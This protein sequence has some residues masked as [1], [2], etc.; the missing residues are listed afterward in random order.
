MNEKLVEIA[1]ENK[2]TPSP[3]AVDALWL[4]SIG[5]VMASSG[6][7][8]W[9]SPRPEVGQ[10]SVLWLPNA[11]LVVALLR[12]WGRHVFSVLAVAIFLGVGLVP[13]FQNDS[14]LGALVLLIVDIIEVG[15]LALGLALWFGKAFRLNSALNVAAFGVVTSVACL[16]GGF[17]A[18][19]VSQLPLGETVIATKAPL[20]V[21]VAWF[22]SDLATYFLV[23]APLL[24]VTGRGG[25]YIWSGLKQA[26]ISSALG[27]FFVMVL[28]FA[29][30]ALPQWL[31]AKTGLA[32]GSGG[33]I[34]VA[35][36]LATYLGFT[37]GP[38]IAA[39]VGAA[40]GVPAI[41]ATMAGIGPFGQGNAAANVFD[42]QAT[43]I[44]C[45]FTL[46]LIGAM[47]DEMRARSSALE[48]ALDEAIKM[49]QNRS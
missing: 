48:R 3:M 14:V 10:V 41:Y 5:V 1:N 19:I 11:I 24:A 49:R 26:P 44:V 42:M 43:L 7:W 39:I 17:L 18:A 12:N 6:I 4:I 38:A 36:P 30:F 16:I 32:L 29:G 40:I 21:G 23:A 13:A 20:Q 9:L 8:T 25:R 33:L 22:T 2:P 35:F 15:F 46:L 37:R 47:A 45:V 34:L 28:T 27:A 31:A